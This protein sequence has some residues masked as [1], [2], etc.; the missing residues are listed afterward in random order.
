ADQR[1]HSFARVLR[2]RLILASATDMVEHISSDLLTR[3]VERGILSPQLALRWRGPGPRARV[4]GEM[5]KLMV[6]AITH[7]TEPDKP[8]VRQN[9]LAI[10]RRD[11]DDHDTL[12]A[13]LAELAT[14]FPQAEQKGLLLEALN[15]ARKIDAAKQPEALLELAAR[16]PQAE[17]KDLVLEALLSAK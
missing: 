2:H 12:A 3:C 13:A 17:Q 5:D 15:H 11:Y 9:V 10:V 1:H 14:L 4:I 16:F 8:S 6:A 7:S